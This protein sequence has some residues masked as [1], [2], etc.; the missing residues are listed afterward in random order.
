MGRVTSFLLG[1][2]YLAQKGTQVN[3]RITPTQAR[4]VA[5]VQEL[6]NACAAVVDEVGI[7]RL[8]TN[9]VAER[10]EC[11]IGTLYRYFP[12]R[13]AV[14]RAL[15]LRHFDDLHTRMREVLRW[16]EPDVAGYRTLL[17]RLAVDF[18]EWHQKTPGSPALGYG[19]LFDLPISE[20]EAALLGGVLRA[21]EVPRLMA[22]R[23]IAQF[24]VP[25]GPA[26]RQVASDIEFVLMIAFSL[27]ERASAYRLSGR[28]SEP[29]YERAKRTLETT[30]MV[31]VLRFE[32]LMRGSRDEA[33]LERLADALM[34][35]MPID[36]DN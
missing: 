6:L 13:T 16:T 9:L 28:D 33:Q 27:I 30:N 23:E 1:G 12:D 3:D 26:F 20:A 19:Y 14:L 31:L 11:S 8:T 34:Q 17:D 22:A 32:E 25:E 15:G 24:F 5:R 2:L 18:L 35:E 36:L 29:C 4:G 21:G 10:A 7:E